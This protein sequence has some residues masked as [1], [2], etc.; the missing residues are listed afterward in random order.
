V[1]DGDGLPGRLLRDHILGAAFPH[2]RTQAIDRRLYRL[3]CGAD[4][5]IVRWLSRRRLARR[6]HRPAQP[7]PD[8][9][10][11][12]HRRGV[13]LHAVAV[14]QRGVVGSGLPAR[15][16]RIGLFFRCRRVPDRTLS[17]EA[18]G[19]RPGLLL[20]FRP[21]HRR[22]VPVPGW[23]AFGDHLARRRDRD[24]WGRGLWRVLPCSLRAAG[25][26]RPGSARRRLRSRAFGARG[27]VSRKWIAGALAPVARA[28][29]AAATTIVRPD[30]AVR[31]ATGYV[32]HNVCSKT[33]VSGFD[34]QIV[35][36]ETI[37]RDGIRRLRPLLRYHLDRTAKIVEASVAGLF[38]SR[39]AFHEGFGCVMLLGPEQ[40]Y[41]LR[42]DIEALK[43]ARTPPLLPEIA[44]PAVV[45]PSDPPLNA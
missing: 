15:L 21:R 4:R 28:A 44:G 5:R 9:L 14:D 30:R 13:A 20:Q 45:D 11:R 39:A 26:A 19:L 3:S 24:L 37:E 36:A 8:L 43:K 34:P 40:P 7:V 17:D 16:L 25:N 31:V 42:S 27:M 12:R 1:A 38:A 29:A 6:P 10:A 32:A 41:L 35:F 18:A 23:R 33:F 22:A 2:H